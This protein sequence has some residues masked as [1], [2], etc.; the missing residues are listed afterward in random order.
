[1]R[2][3]KVQI[4]DFRCIDDSEEFSL[5]P[6][7]CLVGKNESGKTAILKALQ[8]LNPDNSSKESFVPSK[9]Y[10]KRKWRP[11]TAIPEDPP[12]I[13]TT[14]DL[15]DADVAAIED[16]F[17]KGAVQGR[18]FSISKGY[19][20]VRRVSIPVDEKKLL[21]HF[22]PGSKLS[23][24]EMEP[25]TGCGSVDDVIEALKSVAACTPEQQKL[26]SD[27]E[28]RFPKG[29]NM[30]VINFV[31]S[32]L[33]TFLYFDEYLTLPGTVSVTEIAARK[34][35]NDLK[36]K[37]QIFIALLALAGTTVEG[38]NGAGTYEEFN[39]ALRAVSNQITDMIFRYWSQNK[40]LD[41]DI[42][43]DHARPSDPAPFNS[44]WIFRTR[45]DNR[46]HRSD[47]GF[48]ERSRGFVWFFS[49]LIWFNEL[50]KKHGENLIILLDEPGLSL[51]ARAQA[52][53]L[54]YIREQLSPTYQVIYTTHSPFM[55]DPDNLLA[56]RTVEDVVLKN[57]ATGEE[58]LLGTKVSGEV[59]STDADTISPLQRALDYELTQTLFV[60]KNTLLVEGESDLAYL[61]WFSRQLQ[62][63]G[64]PGLD[65]RWNICICGGLSRI[66]GFVSLFRGNGLHIAAI[67]DVQFGDKAKLEN[68]KKTLQSGH[69][70]TADTFAG[71]SEA[72]IEDILGREFYVA[73]V[74]KALDLRQPHEIPES[75]QSTAPARV[76]KE[77]EQ[78]A[79]TLPPNFPEFNHY[80]PAEWLFQHED[81]GRKLAGFEFALGRMEQLIDALNA[82]L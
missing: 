56:S 9:D 61:K 77:V 27:F 41:V 81:E 40:H 64:K 82:L 69:L 44:G 42:R 10:P 46:R 29:G 24:E 51:H 55:I 31:L 16:T 47:T 72:D 75:K 8:K 23:A 35:Q 32:R 67:T 52:D 70:L 12:A 20:N 73:L 2:L 6:V 15:E 49:F 22:L 71:Q 18:A 39:A 17:G 30:A 7:T 19:D 5:D 68:A 3:S 80:L 74:K 57:K 13:K 59:L 50:K 45:I 1:M 34:Q 33:P 63:A 28:A 78:H 26:L 54:K 25:L 66:P 76:A 48:D 4:R 38:V 62:I 79:A 65:Y 37:D 60:G 58:T 11:D 14:W 21:N 43:L 53:L 36:E